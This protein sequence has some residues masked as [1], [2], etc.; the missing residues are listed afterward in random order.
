MLPRAVVLRAHC[1]A[2]LRLTYLFLRCYAYS[3]L[4]GLFVHLHVFSKGCCVPYALFV[5]CLLLLRHL[6][7]KGQTPFLIHFKLSIFVH[8]CVKF[9]LRFQTMQKVDSKN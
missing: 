9:C 4:R 2:L 7:S 8:A 6:D 5:G 3:A 1:G